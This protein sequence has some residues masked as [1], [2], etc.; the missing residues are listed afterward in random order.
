[1]DLNQALE[2]MK[3]DQRMRD[4]YLKHGMVT[5][6]ELEQNLKKLA[7]SGDNAEPVTLEDKGDFAD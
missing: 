4:F 7:D 3:F 2:R 5:R 6:E 1:M